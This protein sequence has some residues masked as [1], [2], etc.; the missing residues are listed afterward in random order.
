MRL[1]LLIVLLIILVGL[2]FGLYTIIKITNK[3]GYVSVIFSGGRLGNQIFEI[4][5]VIAYALKYNKIPI[6]INNDYF[7]T[8]FKNLKTYQGDIVWNHKIKENDKG[9]YDNKS[10]KGNVLFECCYYQ[11]YSNFIEYIPKINNILG[12]K[13]QRNLVKLKYT[14][15]FTNNK[16]KL[17]IH[18]RLGDYKKYK[19]YVLPD[20]YYINAL[21]SININNIDIF[22]FC[23][24]EDKDVVKN[25]MNSG[26]LK[27][28]N[29]QIIAGKNELEELFL[30][31]LCDYIII[32]N[33]T[34]SWWSAVFSGH[35][36][37]YIPNFNWHKETSVK[38]YVL[39][40]WKY[41]EF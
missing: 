25:R 8:I 21:K 30:I 19:G 11:N 9:T 14:Q 4:Y 6:F 38:R 27:S 12:I 13:E 3:T 28:N 15:L 16:K 1:L 26:I 10:L 35:K 33:S 20:Q 40:G 22:V 36:N 23:E 7:T 29:F 5:N 32:A 18:F 2:L 31:S 39:P 24:K 17:G 41:I 34:F 37:V